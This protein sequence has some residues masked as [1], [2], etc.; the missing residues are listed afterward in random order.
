MTNSVKYSLLHPSDIEKPIDMPQHVS[1]LYGQQ[2]FSL[3]AWVIADNM[4]INMS[5]FNNFGNSMGDIC[6]NEKELS[7]SSSFFPSTFKPEYVIADF[8]FCFYRIEALENVFKEHGLTL[9]AKSIKDEFGKQSELREIYDKKKCIIKIEKTADSVKYTNYLR[10]Y[11][12]RLQG[13]F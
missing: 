10:G 13:E 8:Q 3:D 4:Q 2:E 7:F 6:F 9:I 12:Y 1:G 11:Y 5:L